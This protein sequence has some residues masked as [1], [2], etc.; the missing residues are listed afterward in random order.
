MIKNLKIFW[1][2]ATYSMK[3]T[4]QNKVGLVLFTLGKL[5]RFG[6]FFFFVFYL[7]S[8]TELLAGYTLNQTIVFFLT[9]NI[10]DSLAQLLFREVYRFRFLVVSG[11]LNT[12]LVKPYHPFMRILVGGIDIMD[13]FISVIYMILVTYFIFQLP[14][15]SWINILMYLLMIVNGLLIAAGFHIAVLAL[16]VLTTEVDHT[17]MIYRDMT[18]LA[19]FPV[20]I[21][22][23]PLQFIFTFIIPI[24]I[25][26]TFPVKSLLN[27]LSPTIYAICFTLS[28]TAFISSIKLWDYA[29]K[30]YQ[31]W[32]G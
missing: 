7:L 21:Y 15:I 18:R 24:G 29:L 25:M 31:S 11:D 9:Y 30:R 14:G 3:T 23:Q 13:A 1:L 19:T 12:V 17:V 16:G 5:I 26:M 32:G 2:F 20:D 10:V 6:T 22:K 4:L 8:N 28:I 27:L